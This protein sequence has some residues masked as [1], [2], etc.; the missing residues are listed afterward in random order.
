MRRL[1]LAPVLA[2]LLTPLLGCDEKKTTATVT[3]PTTRTGAPVQQPGAPP[4][5]KEQ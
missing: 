3:P 5:P 1:I 4:A 2:G